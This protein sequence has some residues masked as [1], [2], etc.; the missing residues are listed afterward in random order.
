MG[1]GALTMVERKLRKSK[2]G[3]TSRADICQQ[4]R[5]NQPSIGCSADPFKGIQ[6]EEI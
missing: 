1:P 5:S 4:A 3:A 6:K 2:N